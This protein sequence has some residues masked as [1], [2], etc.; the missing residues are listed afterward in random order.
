MKKM[1][2][3]MAVIGL[4][5]VGATNTF[6]VGWNTFVIRNANTSGNSPSIWSDGGYTY[7]GVIEAGQKAG[8]GTDDINGSTIGDIQSISIYRASTSGWGP[9]M[10]F[11]IMDG[12]GNF[13]VLANE[14]SNTG[15]WNPGTAYNTTWDVL[16]DATAKLYEYNTAFT[17]PAG[18]SWTFEDFAGY[19]IAT[20][21]SHQ[22]GNGAPDDLNAGSYTA[23][24]VN[25]VFGD[26]QNN[27]VGTYKVSNPRVSVPEP[28]SI[29]TLIIGLSALLVFRRSK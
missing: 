4:I 9:Y 13:A 21:K 16:K 5:I 28:S 7:F 11:W 3:V 18:A 10:N 12:N 22:G 27:Y 6:A 14:P 26:S 23:Y 15:E 29:I 19:T 25:W 24:G 17:K 20:P 8:W 2:L 1:V